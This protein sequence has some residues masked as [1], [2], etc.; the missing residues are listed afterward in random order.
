MSLFG[1]DGVRGRANEGT[2]TPNTILKIAQAA[3]SIF[4]SGEHRH[5]VIIGKDTRLSGYMIEPALTTGFVSMGMNVVML[6]PMPT[7]AISLLVRS[8]RAD[9]GI[10]ISASHNLYQDNGLKFFGP[11]GYKLSTADQERITKIV[12]ED[13]PLA[14]CA[15]EDLGRAKR[16]E[17]A[18][19]RYVEFIKSTIPRKSRFDGLKIVVDAAH[20]AAYTVASLVFW[21]L[22][23]E[24]VSIG[25][26]PDGKNIN[27]QSGATNTA[28][29]RHHVLAEG[30]NLGVALDGDADRLILIDEKGH[31][32]NGDQ[33]LAVITK[34]LHSHAL[35]K[36]GSVVGTIMSNLGLERFCHDQG[37]GF[38]RTPVGDRHVCDAMR[39]HGCN[40][41]GE[42]SGHIILSDYA[43]TGDGLMAALKVTSQ[44]AAEKKPASEVLSCFKP[45]P[46]ELRSYKTELAGDLLACPVVQE[47]ITQ[48]QH[49]LGQDGRLV[50]RKSGTEPVVRVMVE[51]TNASLLSQAF[52]EIESAFGDK[53]TLSL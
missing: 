14:L 21:E 47:K 25:E 42:Q 52:A 13:Q 24:V 32:V 23:A 12:E 17:S 18:Q 30:A 8:M 22:G 2:L 50:V 38:I 46:Q 27:F 20:G 39:Q 6:G 41:G 31:T 16:L 33:V 9:L 34:C 36:G 44:I 7:P 26:T 28:N 19:G 10:M 43:R 49:S 15:S 51:H 1:T 53:A 35:L 40:I 5:T 45:V 11:D 3:G 37:L 48:L 4:R 29:L